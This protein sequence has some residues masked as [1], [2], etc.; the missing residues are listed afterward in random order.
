ME[1]TGIVVNYFRSEPPVSR[2]NPLTLTTELSLV[3]LK[4]NNCIGTIVLVDGSS[5]PDEKIRASCQDLDIQ[6]LHDGKELS[7]PEA[8]NLG[9]KSLHEPYIG[10]MANDMLP[11]DDKTIPRLISYLEKPDIGCV[12]PYI[13]KGDWPIQNWR[14]FP[15]LEKTCEPSFILLNMLLF[16]RVVLEQIGGVDEG[17]KSGYYDPI[18]LIKTRRLGYRVVLI[19]KTKVV[20]L[21]KLTKNMGESN[22]KRSI[23]KI[24]HERFMVN[25]PEYYFEPFHANSMMDVIWP[26]KFWKWPF[27]TTT[28]IRIL[29]W[30]TRHI[31]F[32]GL[33][34]FLTMMVIF[35]EP[36]FTRYPA[37]YGTCRKK[38]I[39]EE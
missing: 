31:P 7:I 20:H 3:M 11:Y 32:Q 2:L 21:E 37:K 28:S 25:Y 34:K 1:K 15:D 12:L 39:Q 27:S 35:I 36:L 17:Y 13:S 8:Y 16:K 5:K 38:E 4:E 10:L 29:W 18:L 6:Y 9:W 26:Y 30:F 23:G 14:F 33:R 24:D 19:R 22:I